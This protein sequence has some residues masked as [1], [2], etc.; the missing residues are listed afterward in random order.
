MLVEGGGAFGGV[1]TFAG[2]R[3]DG[4]GG[5]EAHEVVGGVAG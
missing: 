5:G 1:V 3:V 4:G 2:V